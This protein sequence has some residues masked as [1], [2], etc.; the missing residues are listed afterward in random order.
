MFGVGKKSFTSLFIGGGTPSTLD[1]SSYEQI[2]NIIFPY[3][4]NGAEI[5]T[6]INPSAK[7]Q[8]LCDI[9]E[10]GVNRVSVGVQS[11]DEKKLKLLGRNHTSKKAIKVIEN[12]YDI[13]IDNISLDLIYDVCIDNKTILSS[14]LDI[15]SS[16]PI[17]HISSYSLTIEPNTIFSK[18]PD[19]KL[20]NDELCIWWIESI[21]SRGFSAY[22]ISNFATSS[23]YECKHNKGYWAY[24]EYIGIGS[25][26]IGFIGNERHISNKD[27]HKYILNP[28]T[29]EY[30]KITQEDMILE[31]I[32][33]GL[34]SN[35]GVDLSIFDNKKISK[36]NILLKENKLTLKENKI[37]NTSYLLS[38]EIVSFIYSY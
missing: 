28:T 11:F 19:M 2:F 12:I 1:I 38:D 6:E 21:S 32:F 36:I 15:A 3:L 29:Y 25:G 22:E 17:T 34:R 10:L 8:W 33:L 27:I 26:S 23:K 4:D 37:F 14:D 24:N 5:T 18:R 13:G 20:D 31:K 35:I 7:K 16:L 9:K 30:E